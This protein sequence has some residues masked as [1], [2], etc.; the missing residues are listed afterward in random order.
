[1]APGGYVA[2]MTPPPHDRPSSAPSAPAPNLGR[3]RA[4]LLERLAENAPIGIFLTDAMGRPVYL[5][6][7]FA[8]ITGRSA[9]WLMRDEWAL[10]VHPDDR[11]RVLATIADFIA[12]GAE[13][14]R[15]EFRI[16]LPD[17]TERRVA[18]EAARA[19]ATG[20]RID[21]FA[22]TVED[23]SERHALEQRAREALKMEAVGRLAGGIA[24]DF[25]NLLTVIR[26][27]TEFL[28]GDLPDGDPR[29]ADA[30]QVLAATERAA[31]LTR[32]LLAFGRR[33]PP[34]TRALDL[35]RAVRNL[36]PVLARVVGSTVHV[37][38]ALAA[39]SPEVKID[40]GQLE[41]VLLNLAQNARE[42]MP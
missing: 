21:G 19:A 17:G 9:E 30:H 41:Q 36:R 24:H 37:E 10:M 25:N 40:S 13:R 22:G 1:M 3:D 38:L 18:S 29:R 16:V 39:E 27:Y 33:Q 6:P 31:A 2:D 7:R 28:A 26:T 5:N 12:S 20:D 35:N 4:A 11:T 15:E 32:Q 14:L 34:A 8:E 42:A 23:I